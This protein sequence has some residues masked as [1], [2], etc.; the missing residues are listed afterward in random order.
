MVVIRPTMLDAPVGELRR[1]PYRVLFPL[2]AVL[3]A[4]GV[5]PWIFFV[6]G[7]SD[8]YRPIFHSVGFRS[9]FHPL[10]ETEGFLAC[11]AVG[12]VL[13]IVPR[14]TLSAPASGWQLALAVAAP[15]A[16]V[17]SAAVQK[18]WLGQAAWLAL[19]AMVIEFVVRRR[20]APGDSSRIRWGSFW[21]ALGLGAG[22]AG[23]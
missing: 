1:E 20:R 19:I 5:L 13:T 2:G 16:I 4:L 3:A 17:I 10:A 23:A 14:R 18:W 22:A 11:F 6:L 8:L 9:M 12:A 7:L 15:I 21:V